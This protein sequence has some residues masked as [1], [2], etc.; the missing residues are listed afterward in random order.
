MSDQIVK[1]AC[2]Q[3]SSTPVIEENM[4]AAEVLIREAADQGA[5]LVITP[6]N[7]TQ[8]RAH[9]PD[10]VEKTLT[11]EEN[12][13]VPFFSDLAKELEIHLLVGSICVRHENGKKLANRAF[14]YNDKGELF[15]NYDKIHMFDVDLANGE[16]YRESNF[17]E[18][19][20]KSVLAPTPWGDVGVTICYDMRFGFLYRTLAKA[21]AQILTAQSAFTVPTGKAHWEVLLRARAIENGCFMLAPAQCG[22]HHGTR[23]TYGHSMI[24]DPWGTILAEAGEEPCVIT[25]DLDLSKVKE[26]RQSV[27]S[28][29]NDREFAF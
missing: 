21:G 20:Y 25:A 29:R 1:A 24:I 26:T 14:F 6:E 22:T 19:G 11:Q 8:I 12:P 10:M 23:Q 13:A 16:S 7:T 15:A 28:L 9:E 27:P 5:K 3:M 4:E 17:Y 2:V 18:P